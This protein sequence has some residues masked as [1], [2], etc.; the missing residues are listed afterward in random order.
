MQ[1]KRRSKISA[2]LAWIAFLTAIVMLKAD[3]TAA[4][5]RIDCANLT[6]NLTSNVEYKE[7]AHRAYAASDQKLNPVYKQLVSTLSGQ[8]KQHL[9]DAQ[10]AWIEFRDSNCDFEIC[11]SLGGTGCGGFLSN[12]VE[13]MTNARTKEL[14]NWRR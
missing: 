5:V 3:S 12:C 9:V 14:Q 8:E 11:R 1:I 10:L 4:Q 7:C 2:S 13:R 6:S